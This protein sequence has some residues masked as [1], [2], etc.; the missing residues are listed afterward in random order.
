MRRPRA[1]LANLFPGGSGNRPGGT[2]T[3]PRGARWT[4]TGRR[5]ANGR[6]SLRPRKRGPGAERVAFGSRARAAVAR[7]EAPRIRKW[8]RARKEYGCADWRATPSILSGAKEK[9]GR[10]TRAANN[11]G[12]DARLN[13]GG[14]C[15]PKRSEGGLFDN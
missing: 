2:M 7:R 12:D 4:G 8:M 6:R 14:A 5:R 1:G 3:L 9:E 11:R 13:V 10:L 15:P